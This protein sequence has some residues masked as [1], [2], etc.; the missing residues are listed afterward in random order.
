LLLSCKEQND[1]YQTNPLKIS[2]NLFY[3]V[4]GNE[5]FN[6][7]ADTLAHLSTKTLKKHLNNDNSKKDFD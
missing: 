6:A 2:Q 7:S 1:S 5:N 3:S 4:K